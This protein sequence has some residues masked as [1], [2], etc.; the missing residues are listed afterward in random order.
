MNSIDQWLTRIFT[1]WKNHNVFRSYVQEKCSIRND[2]VPSSDRIANSIGWFPMREKI[3]VQKFNK[4]R[5]SFRVTVIISGITIFQSFDHR[6][7][8]LDEI[9][10]LF[11]L[12]NRLQKF[13]LTFSSEFV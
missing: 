2:V 10:K 12:E 11:R 8:F 1:N 5:P 9:Q 6:K 3:S 13:E 4:S 7:I